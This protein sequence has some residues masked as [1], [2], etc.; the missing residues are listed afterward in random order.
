MSD[1]AARLANL[2]PEKRALLE[3]RLQQKA[4]VRPAAGA[5]PIAI[6]GMA[7]RFP[8]AATPAAF[9]N[10]IERG[11]D[12]I[13]E[14]PP[15]RWDSQAV[16]D[17]D[18]S[19]PGTT[20]SRYGG[21][22]DDIELFDAPFFGISPREAARM[23]PQQRLFLEVAWE[24]LEDAGQDVDALSG[25]DTGVFVGLHGH[26]NDYFWFDVPHPE[27]MDAFTGPGTSHN[28]VAGRL[29]YLY[30]FQGPAMVVDTACSSSLVAIHLACQS[31]RNAECSLALAGGVN[32]VLSPVFTIALSRLGMLSPDGHCRA[33]DAGANGFVR[34]EGCGVVALKRLEDA[35]AAGDRVLAVIR[36]SA[37]NQ[38]GRTNGITAPSSPSQQRVIARALAHAGVSASQIGY[39]EA[40]GTGTELG[41][42]IEVEALSALIGRPANDG[43]ACFLGSAKANVGHLE[44]AAGVAGLIKAVLALRHKTIPPLALFRAL[45]PHISLD[46]TRL[47]I[48][49]SPQPWQTPH[50]RLAG[51]SSF[52]WSGTN[53]HLIVEEAPDD[54]PS[55]EP[56][57][58][59]A[60]V[61]P[62]SARSDEAARA[63]AVEYVQLLEATPDAFE[64]LSAAAAVRRTHHDFRLAVSGASAA[65]LIN[66]LH[67]Y[68]AGRTAWNA[69][70]D[71]AVTGRKLPAVFVFSGQ[72][73]QWAGM[74]RQL[75]VSNAA[76]RDTVERI[77]A[78]LQPL[79]GWSL[80]DELQAEPARSRLQDTA[81]AQPA[82]FAL[83]VGL[84]AAYKQVGVEPAAVVGHSIG[85]VAAAYVSGALD[86]DEAVRIVFHRGRIMQQAT[87]NGRMVAVE[88][89]A[90]DVERLIARDA[91]LVSLAAINAPRS[92][93]IAG[94]PSAVDAIVT[95]LEADGAI[96][97][98]LPVNYAFHSVQMDNSAAELR[99]VLGTVNARATRVPLVSTVTGDPVDGSTL[100]A[101]YWARNVRSTVQ[102][103]RAI[104]TLQARG[105]QLFLEVSPHPVLAPS[106]RAMRRDDVTPAAVPSLQRGKHEPTALM[107][108]LGALYTR[109]YALDWRKVYGSAAP[110]PLP[111]YPFQR[112]KYWLP[113]SI[114]TSPAGPVEQP[115]M[116][117]AVPGKQLRSPRLNGTIFEC[118]VSAHAPAWLADHLI[119]GEVTMPAAAFVAML[120]AGA[121]R[122]LRSAAI[123]EDVFLHRPLRLADA[124]TAVQ[125]IFEPQGD[126]SFK[127]EISSSAMGETE[128][129]T[130]HVTC[131]ARA[132]AIDSTAGERRVAEDV[133]VHQHYA[134]IARHGAELGPLFQ[135]A[136]R[137]RRGNAYGEA[138]LELPPTLHSEAAR[139]P[140]HPTV[141]D[142]ALQA[143]LAA[144]PADDARR[145]MA[146]LPQSFARVGISSAA[147]PV[148]ARAR[149]RA[150]AAGDTRITAD[151]ELLD[152]AGATVAT[153]TGVSFAAAK[154]K[155]PAA[156]TLIYAEQWVAN[157]TAAT[158][159]SIAGGR[160]I[161][162]G[163]RAGVSAALAA[164]LRAAGGE[165]VVIEPGDPLGDELCDRREG[166][167]G[168]VCTAM[169]DAVLPDDAAGE[170]LP[171]LL[172]HTGG[173]VLDVLQRLTRAAAPPPLYIVTRNAQPAGGA[174]PAPL[175]STVWGLSRIVALEHPDLRCVCIDV[176]HE[177]PIDTLVRELTRGGDEREV[178]LRG[179][180]R[181]V[182]RLARATPEQIGEQ[183]RPREAVALDSTQR[184]VLDNLTMAPRHRTEPTGG[185]LEIE[186]RA[187]GLN[188]RDVLN[189]LGV[190]EGP[191]GPF[192]CE[193]AGVVTAVGAD[194]DGL[195]PGDRVFGVPD[196]AMASHVVT[197]AHRVVRMPD[198][199]SFDVAAS[200][201]IAFL[202]ARY[203]LE[204]V[205]ALAPGERV[206]IHAAAGGVGLAA[207]QVARRRGAEIFATAGSPEKRRMLKELGVQHVFNS[208]DVAFAADVMRAS[209]G[210]G[211]DVALNS[212]A[213]AFIPATLGVLAP[214]GR[215]VEIG[216]A[217]IWTAEQMRAARPDVR[218]EPL[219]LGDV[220][221]T[222]PPRTQ[223]MLRELRDAVAAG[224]LGPLPVETFAFERAADAF[225]HMAQARH[226]GKIVL[227]HGA[228]S[229]AHHTSRVVA[230]A[231]YLIT[232][233]LG[234][235]GL[236]VA[237]RLV[238]RGARHLVLAGRSAPGAEAQSTIAALEARGARVAVESMDVAQRRDVDRLLARLATS[239]PPV[240]GLVHAAGVLDDGV[241]THQSWDR[242]EHV[243]RPKIAG[244]W[245][246]HVATREL[247]L[248]F[249]LMFSA[250]ATALGSAGQSNYASAN[251][252]MDALAHLRRSENLPALSINWGPWSDGGMA[253]TVSAETQRRWSEY[254]MHFMSTADALDAMELALSRHEC[255]VTIADIEWDRFARSYSRV[256]AAF[257]GLVR[258]S[259]S[260]VSPRDSQPDLVAALAGSA[261]VRRLGLLID[262]VHQQA[263][264]VLG[265]P[266][267]YPLDVHQGLRD[268][269][270]DSLMAVELRNRLQASVRQP[271]ATTLAFDCPTVDAL[272]RH[273]AAV[274]QLD[275]GK[276]S[277]SP[278][279]GSLRTAVDEVRDLT[280][281]EAMAALNAEFAAFN[282]TTGR[283]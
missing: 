244:S 131:I 156:A 136:Q 197:G 132:G 19:R 77:S 187:S 269:G 205:A 192:G 108:S 212:L 266:D 281:E 81:V 271:L 83:Q 146:Y 155:Q 10:L 249:F 143:V 223:R 279:G 119:N 199:M 240:R 84:V 64:R 213:G 161:V 70:S 9:W 188:F 99:S 30:D 137:L 189:A 259:P 278:D 231:T 88:L 90:A 151:L 78:L 268:V 245:N 166:I 59:P 4:D 200:L 107:A 252:F 67:E 208:R 237:Q 214:A 162:A 52:G 139:Y 60:V 115:R 124:T 246:L 27:R 256:P 121:E 50:R 26:A 177:C 248:D 216:K 158:G 98:P 261:P 265:L 190:Y 167:A 49:T 179:T 92:C 94:Q 122:V 68:A 40:H 29:S 21:F 169:V 164:A 229:A 39:I 219:Y 3:K 66:A 160:W 195:R 228:T 263:L 254:G 28:I 80:I 224:T 109:G 175:Q 35:R 238:D 76:F 22:L 277:D 112:A 43:G 56:S 203:A 273:L 221:V 42:P 241:L 54:R 89:P 61:L 127:V 152:A 79:A 148:G 46:G 55:A 6:V 145:G 85:E 45:N 233:G 128:G 150:A 47:A 264:A 142:G 13:R 258:V 217:G 105:H 73:P 251:A 133:D 282:S 274:L 147:L 138:D 153:V 206:L 262:H 34:S 227:S 267:S 113:E 17:A 275:L 232:G 226:V 1:L 144:L 140:I 117:D 163:D 225:R 38:D 120:A 174:V 123:L 172:G 182:R 157:A 280:D 193:C 69:A 96:C 97:R 207:V 173:R 51:V 14:V 141:L 86:L 32:L 126:G 230:D 239:M 103:A 37:V 210:R 202:T 114:A 257:G 194:V 283:S 104:S 159:P 5:E 25:S 211:V 75:L 270:L 53:A 183:Q 129:W 65:E 236:A 220:F 185:A 260:A 110:M 95:R 31:L 235:L 72:G 11:G 93:V 204:D 87:G 15:A 243:M 178:A 20:N 176:D 191:P 181:Y 33:F 184:G 222:D 180:Q 91:A 215:F 74:G 106:I 234:S 100:D 7:C 116:A 130:T 102:F 253:R 135:T 101:D 186:V 171:A 41:D 63:L 255:H 48:P 196:G 71:R 154:A 111:R 16:Y 209:S 57:Q 272:S 36:G 168:V 201:P 170:G 247:P 18:T 125:T 165:C 24:A 62:I 218:Y 276:S 12:A 250:A 134:L 58:L 149:L 242:F 82:L 118:E 23:D 2:S 198:G 8:G 44:G